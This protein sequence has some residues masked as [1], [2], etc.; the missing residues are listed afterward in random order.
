MGPV[1][2]VRPCSL[3]SPGCLSGWTSAGLAPTRRYGHSPASLLRGS[4]AGSALNH[5]S[6]AHVTT[7]EGALH[8]DQYVVTWTWS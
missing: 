4:T 2:G 6:H 3:R 7:D 8:A 1:H 5:T